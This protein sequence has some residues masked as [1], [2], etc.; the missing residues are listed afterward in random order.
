MPT[1]KRDAE[2]SLSN[3]LDNLGNLAKLWWANAHIRTYESHKAEINPLEPKQFVQKSSALMG[4]L[5]NQTALIDAA[6]EGAGLSTHNLDDIVSTG[7]KYKYYTRGEKYFYSSVGIL[8]NMVTSFTI[9]GVKY[10]T[11][12]YM[13]MY[14]D[15]YRQKGYDFSIG[16]GRHSYSKRPKVNRPEKKRPKI[17]RPKRNR[18]R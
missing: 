11:Q 15:A 7:S 8:N 14:G 1:N 17:K 9:P 13:N 6:E 16:S 4:A 12:F 2:L 18:N 3:I 5:D 10:N